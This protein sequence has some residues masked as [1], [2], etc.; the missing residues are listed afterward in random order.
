MIG[1]FEAKCP[2]YVCLLFAVDFAVR[3]KPL[4]AGL[5]AGLAFS[6]HTAVGLWGGAALGWAVMLHNPL[7]RTAWYC[8]GVIVASLPGLI[9]SWPLVMG[10]HAISADDSRFLVTTALPLCLDPFTFSKAYV[11]LLVGMI[12]FA[13]FHRWWFAGNRRI[14]I[15]FQFEFG[16]A[17]FFALAFVARAMGR[18]DLLKLYMSRT[19]GVF[20]MLLFFWQL[21]SILY[22]QWEQ[23]ARHVERFTPGPMS[24]G[25]VMFFGILLFLSLP[26]PVG[27][28]CKLIASHVHNVQW[29]D[30]ET[31]AP[32]ADLENIAD[33]RA[34]ADWISKNTPETDIVIAPPWRADAY[35][36][37]RRPLIADWHA[38]RYDDMPGWRARIEAMVGD[39]SNTDPN[40]PQ[41]GDMDLH[42]REHF[43]HLTTADISGLQQKYGGSWLITT[44]TYPYPRRFSSGVFNVYKLPGTPSPAHWSSCRG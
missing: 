31:P 4:K 33:F 23:R 25:P 44:T 22:S 39:L 28:L 29:I 41:V 17:I 7:R 38:F 26:S 13:A 37:L 6:F 30:V 32:D 8:G 40:D 15:L 21:A 2:A 34:A 20:A 19:Y 14:S 35:Y 9:S 12:I 27:Q 10:A 24:H 42:A 1:S 43:R 11:A 16:L 36:F 3:D 5:L 18:F